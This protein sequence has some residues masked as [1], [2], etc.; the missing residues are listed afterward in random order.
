MI[1][2]SAFKQ[3]LI[4]K[5]KVRE[6]KMKHL[7]QAMPNNVKNITISVL[8]KYHQDTIIYFII[9]IMNQ[10]LFQ[11]NNYFVIL[12]FSSFSL[13]F[14]VVVLNMS[15]SFFTVQF[16]LHEISWKLAEFFLNIKY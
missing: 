1:S 9:I 2:Y 16:K 12:M 15:Y 8:F 4:I 6:N 13:V 10:Y 7:N 11:F 14:V 3:F 5:L